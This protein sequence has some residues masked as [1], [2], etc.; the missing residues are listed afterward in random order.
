ML[1]FVPSDAGKLVT[2][3][4][5]YHTIVPPINR[6]PTPG[7]PGSRSYS[8][9]AETPLPLLSHDTEHVGGGSSRCD[10]DHAIDS[11]TEE[12]YPT[13]LYTL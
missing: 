13:G 8:V 6:I 1:Y 10:Y 4:G 3:I 7:R 11:V 12:N 2:T 5:R 9:M